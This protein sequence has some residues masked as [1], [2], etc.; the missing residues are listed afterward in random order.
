M[1]VDLV[2]KV[3][4]RL[5]PPARGLNPIAPPQRRFCPG[6]KYAA[7]VGKPAGRLL[8]QLLSGIVFSAL[9][10]CLRPRDVA[11]RLVGEPFAQS[12]R[13]ARGLCPL[14][15]EMRDPGVFALASRILR[16]TTLRVDGQRAGL[17]IM[18]G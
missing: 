4:L 7:V 6:S 12:R 18:P 5:A 8:D 16:T 9:P 10:Q 1:K 11:P 3:L 17:L 15:A 2:R 13:A 14:A